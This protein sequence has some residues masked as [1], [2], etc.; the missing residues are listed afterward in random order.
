MNFSNIKQALY[1]NRVLQ[2]NLFI[3]RELQFTIQNKGPLR[4]PQQNCQES[5]STCL[6][7]VVGEL[8]FCANV[9]GSILT[10][11]AH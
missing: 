7:V 10:G 4:P 6:L 1:Y 8:N 2:E 11:A 5:L 3:S 9:C